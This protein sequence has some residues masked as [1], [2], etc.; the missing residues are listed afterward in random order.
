MPFVDSYK[1]DD[2]SFAVYTVMEK[3]V[4]IVHSSWIAELGGGARPEAARAMHRIPA[5][6]PHR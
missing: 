6:R 2:P 5:R 1:S 3:K 4:G